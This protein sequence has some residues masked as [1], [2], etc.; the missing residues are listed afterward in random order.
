[1]TLIDESEYRKRSSKR[2]RCSA[3]GTAADVPGKMYGI[4][5]GMPQVMFVLT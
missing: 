2:R 1:M 4:Q 3:P 5:S